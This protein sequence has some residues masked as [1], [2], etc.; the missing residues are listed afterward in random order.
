M[1]RP[2]STRVRRSSGSRG[3]YL[4]IVGDASR[5][6][7]YLVGP[8][9]RPLKTTPSSSALTSSCTVSADAD[10]GE[11][12]RLTVLDADPAPR[13]HEVLKGVEGVAHLLWQAEPER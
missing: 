12:I 4:G 3:D 5:L 8:S 1:Q 2:P 11:Q 10:A 9:R 7:A 13:Q 6:L